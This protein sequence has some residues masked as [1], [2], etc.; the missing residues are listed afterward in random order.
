VTDWR[1]SQPFKA[2]LLDP[3]HPLAAESSTPLEWTPF[4]ARPDGLV[5]VSR[6]CGRLGSEPD[7]IVA[8]TT[9]RAARD[10]DR[11]F[12]FGYS[13]EIRVFLNGRLLF[14][15]ESAYTQRDPSFLGIV[16]PY[17]SLYLPLRKGDND[18]L[19]VVTERMG[20]WGFQFL[21]ATARYLAPGVERAWSAPDGLSLPESA[22]YDPARNAIYVSSWDGYNP[23]RGEPRQFLSRFSLDGKLETLRWVDGLRNP[24][25]IAVRGDTLLAVEPRGLAEI[26]IPSATIRRRIPIPDAFA[27]NDVAIGAGGEAFLSDSR[28]DAIFRVADGRAEEWLSGKEIARPNGLLVAGGTLYL[29]VN[30]DG[31]LKAVDLATKA[32]RVVADLGEGTIDGIQPDGDGSLLVTHNEGRL[33]RVSQDGKV[34]LLVDGTTVQES[35][36]DIGYVPEKRMVVAPTFTGNGVVAYRLP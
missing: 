9:L 11:R 29:G 1:L 17:D 35:L 13:D 22:A 31:R 14:A 21:D 27:L 36:A 3:E 12:R 10:E 2:R 26:D 25:G 34:T 15:G 20:G 28:K 5:D 19:V 23:S 30:G 18:L 32:I 33:F 7:S 4:A 16:G 24:S 6:H 8:R